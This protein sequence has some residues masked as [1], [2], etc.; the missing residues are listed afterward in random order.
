MEFWIHRASEPGSTR[1]INKK[2]LKCFT[3]PS[4]P[5]GLVCY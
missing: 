2:E 5:R 3:G 1:E 4:V